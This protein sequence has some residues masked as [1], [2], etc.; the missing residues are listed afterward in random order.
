MNDMVNRCKVNKHKWDK[1]RK[2][3][4]CHREVEVLGDISSEEG[5]NEKPHLGPVFQKVIKLT[6]C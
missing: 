4:V 1:L 6:T 5:G 3:Q 2:Y